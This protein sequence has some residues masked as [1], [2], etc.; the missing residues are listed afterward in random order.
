MGLG[1]Q[2]EFYGCSDVAITTSGAYQPTAKTT[3]IR[4]PTTT[5]RRRTTT[6]TSPTKPTL[7]KPSTHSPIPSTSRPRTTSQPKSTTTTAPKY[8][9]R[10]DMK[11]TAI[12][13]WEGSPS[14]DRWCDINCRID[15]CP[16][17]LCHCDVTMTTKARSASTVAPG[18]KKTCR[19]KGDW[20]NKDSMDRWCARN[21]PLGNCSDDVCECV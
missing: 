11:C 20:P 17:N 6:T 7:S 3:T 16:P 8:T 21:C 5:T 19:S 9:S 4:P 15:N 18:G 14:Q 1:P 13:A 2:E 12:G 10:P